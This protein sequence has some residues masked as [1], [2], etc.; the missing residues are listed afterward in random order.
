LNIYQRRTKRHQVQLLHYNLTVSFFSLGLPF[1]LFAHSYVHYMHHVFILV[2]IGTEMTVYGTLNFPY[3]DQAIFNFQIDSNDSVNFT[4]PSTSSAQYSQPFFRASGLPPNQMHTLTVKSLT[5]AGIWLD[6]F[7]YKTSDAPN[8]NSPGSGD[9]NSN[10]KTNIGA[11]VGGVVGGVAF[12]IFV[13]IA[14]F[15][16]FKRRKSKKE[17][18]VMEE[19]RHTEPVPYRTTYPSS[20]PTSNSNFNSGPMSTNPNLPAPIQVISANSSP[21]AVIDTDSPPSY[22]AYSPPPTSTVPSGSTA[23]SG[24][25]PLV[26]TRYKYD[27]RLLQ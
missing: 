27:T 22:G 19:R 6:Y 26:D 24:E 4:T 5:T 3:A 13:V 1:T 15:F 8:S 17:A 12:I 7:I 11:I 10:S 23:D 20:L 14:V 25:R 2:P 18:A 16:L 21:R 9:G